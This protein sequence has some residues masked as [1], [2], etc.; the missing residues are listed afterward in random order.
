MKPE[1]PT[2]IGFLII[3]A[4]SLFGLSLYQ[5]ARFKEE[6]I[7]HQKA[8][9]LV[10]SANQGCSETILKMWHE[11][12]I[13][14]AITSK[15]VAN[16]TTPEGNSPLHSVVEDAQQHSVNA[17]KFVLSYHPDMERQNADNLTPLMLTVLRGKAMLATLLLKAGAKTNTINDDEKTA[18]FYARRN[19]EMIP[20][21]LNYGAYPSQR[22]Y[23]L[24]TPLH[25]AALWGNPVAVDLLIQAGAEISARDRHGRTPL[26]IAV[27]EG[28]IKAKTERDNIEIITK[29]IY[30]GADP[31]TELTEAAH[32][33]VMELAARSQT[34]WDCLRWSSQR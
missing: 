25:E 15:E 11:N 12:E 30:A 29:L 4:L 1:H 5:E 22:D 3:L 8:V 33:I 14:T 18:L 2:L 23:W 20:L 19:P 32:S 28:R 24:M 27:V 6:W 7:E 16:C 9:A 17:M 21:L 34:L 26:A 13:A 10:K 31:E